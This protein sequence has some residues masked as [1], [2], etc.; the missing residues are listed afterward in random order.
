M[1]IQKHY[2]PLT[3]KRLEEIKKIQKTETIY[4]IFEGETHIKEDQPTTNNELKKMPELNESTED[5]YILRDLGDSII[6][7]IMS[8]EKYNKYINGEVPLSKM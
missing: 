3:K 1:D 6:P 5:Y 2:E 4:A 8:R 7:P